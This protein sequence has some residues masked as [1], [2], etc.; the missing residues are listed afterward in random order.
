M[1]D[2]VPWETD[3]AKTLQVA[4]TTQKPVLLDFFNPG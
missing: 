4:R 3:F 1:A 2:T